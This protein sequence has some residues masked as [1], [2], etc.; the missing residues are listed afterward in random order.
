RHRAARGDRVVIGADPLLTGD[1]DLTVVLL[2][3]GTTVVIFVLL[4]VAVML[5]IWFM[6]KV[7][8]DMQNRIGP[9]KDGTVGVMQ[10]LAERRKLFFKEQ[11]QPTTSDKQVF[12]LAPY[13]S[14]VPAFL[15][16]A[17]VPIG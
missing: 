8:A 7:I 13:L 4:L 2:V 3:I 12:R 14:I 17:I 5:Y 6:R 11:S 10:T 9:Q 15:A 16:F 1:I